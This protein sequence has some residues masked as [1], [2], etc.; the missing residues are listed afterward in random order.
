[1]D[2]FGIVVIVRMHIGNE[3]DEVGI[4]FNERL[5]KGT[6]KCKLL[7]DSTYD[8]K[9]YGYTLQNHIWDMDVNPMSS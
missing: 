2:Y 8:F 7:F 4:G 3:T 1:M 6:K 5:K 9:K